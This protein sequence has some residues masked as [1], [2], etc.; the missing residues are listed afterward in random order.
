[1]HSYFLVLDTALVLAAETVLHELLVELLEL[2]QDSSQQLSPVLVIIYDL[3]LNCLHHGLVISH[4]ET[5]GSH[6]LV[7]E[8]ASN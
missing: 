4:I 1:V 3:Q 7:R 6:I 8:G 2:R 5:G